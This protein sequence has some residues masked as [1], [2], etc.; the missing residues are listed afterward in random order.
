MNHTAQPQKRETEADVNKWDCIK[1]KIFC[2]IRETINK[3]K[4]KMIFANELSDKW[5]ILKI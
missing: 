5:L 4:R 2:A 3:T 1:L